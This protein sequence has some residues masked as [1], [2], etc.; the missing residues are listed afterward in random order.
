MKS[1]VVSY[2]FFTYPLKTIQN[3]TQELVLYMH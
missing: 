1:C 3:T 2:I